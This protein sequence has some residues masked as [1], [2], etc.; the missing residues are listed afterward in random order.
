MPAASRAWQHV[1]AASDA[2]PDAPVALTSPSPMS[3]PEAIRA[4]SAAATT[5]VE[6]VV[7][8]NECMVGSHT[9]CLGVASLRAPETNNR[10]V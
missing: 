5:A 3:N 9:T 7:V 6:V 8:M 1:V 4:R 10:L 2:V